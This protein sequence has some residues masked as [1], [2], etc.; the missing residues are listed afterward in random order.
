MK[1]FFILYVFLIFS[2][3]AW[4]SRSRVKNIHLKDHSIESYSVDKSKEFYNQG[5]A[6]LESNQ[7]TKAIASFRNAIYS[8]PWNWSAQIA[9][10]KLGRSLPL[11]WMI[12]YEIFLLIV[13]L[14][15]I[16]L[17]FSLKIWRGV[18]LFLSIILSSSFW[19]YRTLPR[20]TILQ[21]TSILSAPL[22]DSPVIFTLKE[23]SFVTQI[24]THNKEW[25]QIKNNEGSGWLQRSSLWVK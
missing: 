3:E 21:D 12:P 13:I 1:Y 8:D 25:V 2:L 22:E 20:W 23:S 16:F 9:L 5:V 11:W 10:K 17:L 6:L 19:Y 14:G 18:F 4:S 7:N 15:L 24:G